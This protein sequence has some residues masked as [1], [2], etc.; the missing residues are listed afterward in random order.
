MKTSFKLMLSLFIL[1]FTGSAFAASAE[2]LLVDCESNIGNIY[3]FKL[4]K[5]T[6]G[7]VFKVTE[8]SGSHHII[9]KATETEMK[10]YKFTIKDLR[11][12]SNS[13]EITIFS[14]TSHGWS[15]LIKSPGKN[16][17]W[18]QF[19]ANLRCTGPLK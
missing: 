3:N 2:T 1:A 13:D 7:E 19:V 16:P 8:V 12:F 11:P 6:S 9:K 10:Q 17:G 4:V 14:R 15:M 18:Q 5:N